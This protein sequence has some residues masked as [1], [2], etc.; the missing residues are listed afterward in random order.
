MTEQHIRDQLRLAV[1]T[2]YAAGVGDAV[3]LATISLDQAG[4][5]KR[6]AVRMLLLAENAEQ[7][8][9]PAVEAMVQEALEQ[10]FDGRPVAEP[11]R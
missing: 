7:L 10:G 9:L 6:R 2:A 1:E 8:V 4:R 3:T 11:V 5:M